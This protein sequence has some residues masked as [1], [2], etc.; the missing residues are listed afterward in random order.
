[1][2]EQAL[3]HRQV[4]VFELVTVSPH[5]CQ[6]VLIRG[7]LSKQPFIIQTRNLDVQEEKRDN[8][9]FKKIICKTVKDGKKDKVKLDET[10]RVRNLRK[11]EK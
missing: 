7:D 10:K 11:E 2:W 4:V 8:R 1:M 5:T 3:H 9:S 6:R